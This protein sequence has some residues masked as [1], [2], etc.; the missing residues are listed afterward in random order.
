MGAQA[1]AVADG[2]AAVDAVSRQ[3]FDVVLMDVQMPGMD[4]LEATRRIRA[5]AGAAGRL[6]VVALTA[7]ITS[8]RRLACLEAGMDAIAIKPILPKHLLAAILPLVQTASSTTEQAGAATS[9]G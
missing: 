4:G 2:E 3:S 5:L 1:L 9:H 6:P 8:E 7:D